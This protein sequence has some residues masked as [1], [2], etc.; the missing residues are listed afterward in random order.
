M[1]RFAAVVLFVVAASCALGQT[2]GEGAHAATSAPSA[3]DRFEPYRF[4]AGGM[5][6]AAMQIGNEPGTYDVEYTFE[7]VL[8]GKFLQ[9]RHVTKREGKQLSSTLSM[10]GWD[11]QRQAMAQW[12]FNNMGMTAVLYAPQTDAPGTLAFE[13][14]LGGGEKAPH[15]RTTY[16]RRGENELEVKTEFLR[17]GKYTLAGTVTLVRK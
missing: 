11:A 9:S 16:V 3:V 7:W 6:T 12:G 14:K 2:S 10:I 13:G 17:D 5:W 15:V 1:R 8:S 4:L